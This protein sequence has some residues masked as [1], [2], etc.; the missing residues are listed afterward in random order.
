MLCTYIPWRWRLFIQS[1]A[2]STVRLGLL[3]CSCCSTSLETHWSTWT[4]QLERAWPCS[5][6]ALRWVSNLSQPCLVHGYGKMYNG[7]TAMPQDKEAEGLEDDC[8]LQR[9]K[10]SV[11]HLR[12][13]PQH[14]SFG[15]TIIDKSDGI[16]FH[17]T[18]NLA[19][20]LL[21]FL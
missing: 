6:L 5:H 7:P 8:G 15:E 20:F 1:G 21:E 11:S 18:L 19:N 4:I 2:L 13:G 16:F 3:A 17:A 12:H 10:Y 9:T 14:C